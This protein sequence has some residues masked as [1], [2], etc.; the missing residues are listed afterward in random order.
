[1][2]RQYRYYDL[3]LAAFVVVLLCSNF[4]GAGKTASVYLPVLGQIEF[5]A[6]ILFFPI[7]YFFA[8]IVTEVYGY[9]YDRRAV[10]AGFSALLFAAMMAQIVIALPVGPGDYMANYQK[11]L[12]TVFGNSWR[13]ALASIIAFWCGSFTNAYVMA[14]MKVWTKGKLLWSR[15]IGSTAAGELVDSSLFY[16]IA[17]YA[18]WDINDIVKVAIAQYILKTSWEIVATPMTYAV[19]NF[20]KRKEDEDYF[21]TNTNFTPFRLKVDS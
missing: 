2:R 12:E 8:D 5:G 14:K 7:S 17:F 4:I 15:T 10:W 19:V 11:G 3:I 16:V 21:D 1:M 6:G 18:I 9:A 13:V 20:L